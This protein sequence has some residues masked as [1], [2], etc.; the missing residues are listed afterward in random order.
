MLTKLKRDEYLGAVKYAGEWHILALYVGEWILNYP[1]YDPYSSK[2]PTDKY[3][4]GLWVVNE[5]NAAEFLRA[6]QEHELS[7]TEVE[8]LIAEKGPEEVP[9]TYVVNFDEK[10]FV[11]GHPDR[12]IAEYV[13][14]G[15][16]GIEDF[17]T[18][19]VPQKIKSLW[20][21]QQEK[22]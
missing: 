16:T 12:D 15:W 13:P 22:V 5:T 11:D 1:A 21:G 9:L 19:Y 10:L 17:P 6:M 20:Q 14:E 8:K 3:R 2:S 18:N 4:N 7:L